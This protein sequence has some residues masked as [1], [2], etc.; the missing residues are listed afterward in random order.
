M[1]RPHLPSRARPTVTQ[2]VSFLRLSGRSVRKVTQ[3]MSVC[4]LMQVNDYSL[5]NMDFNYLY[6]DN[7]FNILFQVLSPGPST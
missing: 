5:E 4:D 1:G 3:R 6:L 7:L 2:L